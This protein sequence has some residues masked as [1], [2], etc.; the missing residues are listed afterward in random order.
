MHLTNTYRCIIVDDNEL[1]RLMTLSFVKKYPFLSVEGVYESAES[2][3]AEIDR[4][5]P[6]VLLLDVDMEGLS[7]LE[8]RRRLM[9]ADVCIFITSY[10]DYAVE[11]FE[12]AALDF[13]VKPVKGERFA[14]AM[15]RLQ[16]YLGLCRKSVLFDH[17]LNGDTIFIKDGKKHIK[18]MRNDILYLEALKDYTRIVTR[19][20]KYCVFSSLGNLLKDNA[21]QSF[22][23]IHRSFAVQKDFIDAITVQDV[24]INDIK[25]PVGRSYRES[26]RQLMG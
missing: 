8:M 1:D 4:T 19:E 17:R 5:R 25:I 2:A 21:F 22:I 26:V 20:K 9:Q 10:P 16:A 11:S 13:L 14:A 23:R 15:E 6:Q 3:L 12:L 7:G 24:S 18:I